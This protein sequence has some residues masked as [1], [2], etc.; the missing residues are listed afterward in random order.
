MASATNNCEE[1][2]KHGWV[3]LA[4]LRDHREAVVTITVGTVAEVG[5]R[6]EICS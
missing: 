3:G 5:E 4:C 1:F 2:E 6:K